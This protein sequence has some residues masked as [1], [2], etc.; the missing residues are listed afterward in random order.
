MIDRYTYPEMKRVWSEENKLEK[1]LQVELLVCEA[2]ARRGAI[3]AAD[4]DELRRARLDPERMVE[5]FRQTHH[6]IVSFVRSV[7]ETVGP[8]GRFLHLGL[9]S[10]DVLDTAMAAQI[11]EASQILDRD[12]EALEHALV[13]QAQ[14]HKMAAMIGRTHGMHAE[15]MTF[16]FKLAGWVAEVRR[17]RDR[18]RA[19]TREAAVGKIS[20]AVGTHANVPPD[21]E[22]EVCRALGLEAEPVSTQIVPRDRH[23]VYISTLGLIASSLERFATEVRALQRTDIGEVYEPFG[24]GQQGSSAMPHKRNPELAERVCGLAR[25]IRSATIPAMEDVALWHERDISHSSVERLIFPDSCLALDYILRIFTHIV[26]FM[27]VDETRMRENLERTGGLVYSGRVLLALVD[28]G[29]GRNDAYEL[30]QGY[31][32]DVWRCGGQ[33]HDLLAQDPAVQARLNPA[34]LNELFDLGYHLRYV[35]TAF[36]RLSIADE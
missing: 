26:S 1:W 13:A 36:Q 21:I 4:M 16:G 8:P 33:L 18:L 31:A 30:V 7:A 2:W 25:F 12:L 32:K 17:G 20:G 10:S 19:A 14:R 22:E 11:A 3:P 6:D 35:D 28:K 24:E 34:E 27:D 15:P 5:L 29:M 23:A 9:T